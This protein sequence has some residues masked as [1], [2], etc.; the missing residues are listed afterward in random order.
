MLIVVAT[1]LVCSTADI[2]GGLVPQLQEWTE[3]SFLVRSNALPSASASYARG[4]GALLSIGYILHDNVDDRKRQEELWE[5]TSARRPLGGTTSEAGLIDAPIGDTIRKFLGPVR[6]GVVYA[7]GA[8]RCQVTVKLS[9]PGM[10]TASRSDWRVD[11]PAEHQLVDDIARR[12][13]ARMKAY[14]LFRPVREATLAPTVERL[15]S[16]S[17][18]TYT[19]VEA[20]AR[21]KGASPTSQRNVAVKFN[22][23]GKPVVAMSGADSVKVSDKWVKLGGYVVEVNNKLFAPLLGLNAAVK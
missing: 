4:D 12:V 13:V 1:V 7:I 11:V 21:S 14:E 2:L 6:Y 15:N 18:A 23:N 3:R 16:D 10:G 9:Y 17:G 5:K 8:G 22:F 19:S 20:W